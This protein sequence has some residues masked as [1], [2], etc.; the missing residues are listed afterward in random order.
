MD[1]RVSFHTLLCVSFPHVSKWKY[2]CVWEKMVLKS[3]RNGVVVTALQLDLFMSFGFIIYL[4]IYWMPVSPIKVKSTSLYG[5]L[6]MHSPPAPRPNPTFVC[7]LISS[8][9]FFFLVLLPHILCCFN[10]FTPLTSFLYLSHPPP[11]SLHS[12]SPF[13]LLSLLLKST[14]K[15]LLSLLLKSPHSPFFWIHFQAFF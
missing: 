3:N 12:D 15:E 4:K 9:S 6:T 5:F 13:Y 1:W 7:I 10:L 11:S 14:F 2:F 8:L